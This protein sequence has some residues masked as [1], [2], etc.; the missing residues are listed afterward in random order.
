VLLLSLTCAA[1]S[2]APDYVF[3]IA[4]YNIE[5]MDFSAYGLA[6]SSAITNITVV[7]LHA[8]RTLFDY[9]NM[10]TYSRSSILPL[11][12]YF[13]V[14]A[15]EWIAL[16]RFDDAML[17]CEKESTLWVFYRMFSNFAVWNS[18]A[19]L[20]CTSII[21]SRNSNKAS[22]YFPFQWLR[23]AIYYRCICM[24]ICECIYICIFVYLYI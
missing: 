20:G 5:M 23:C 24:C 2:N 12:R 16:S 8:N 22:F 18:I 4:D 6:S 10:E 13:N 7:D 14:T 9:C 1:A 19:Q 15:K 17:S 11:L 3:N 21:H